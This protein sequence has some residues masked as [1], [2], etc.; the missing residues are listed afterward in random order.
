MVSTHVCLNE[1]HYSCWTQIEVALTDNTENC[2]SLHI[3]LR[4]FNI[5]A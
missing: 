2:A 1:V 4:F 3:A 5:S